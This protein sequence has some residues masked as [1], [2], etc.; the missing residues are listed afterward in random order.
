MSM[1]QAAR[2]KRI[3]ERIENIAGS[4]AVQLIDVGQFLECRTAMQEMGRY[5]AAVSESLVSNCTDN[6]CC[7][8]PLK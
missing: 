4:D 8:T 2:T 3:I 1:S 7:R 5:V 6:D